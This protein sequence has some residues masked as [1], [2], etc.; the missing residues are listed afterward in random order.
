MN[1]ACI[2]VIMYREDDA[3]GA[4]AVE[5][6]SV[7]EIRSEIGDSVEMGFKKKPATLQ[8]FLLL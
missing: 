5:A 8:P 4:C 7:F 1:R 6:E 3:V 2:Y